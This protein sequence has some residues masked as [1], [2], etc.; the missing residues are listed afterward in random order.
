VDVRP[1]R[2]AHSVSHFLGVTARLE[3]DGPHFR[4]LREPINTSTLEGMFSLQ[5]F[6]TGRLDCRV[7]RR[8]P[9]RAH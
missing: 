9:F 1:D 5:A 6:G 4:S 7:D 3:S 8:R 2:L